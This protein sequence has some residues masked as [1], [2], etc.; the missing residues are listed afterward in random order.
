MQLLGELHHASG[1]LSKILRAVS[2]RIPHRPGFWDSLL[3]KLSFSEKKT[4][5]FG[6]PSLSGLVWCVYGDMVFSF[7]SL[8]LEGGRI[9]RGLRFLLIQGTINDCSSSDNYYS[10]RLPWFRKHEDST[11]VSDSCG[12]SMRDSSPRRLLSFQALWGP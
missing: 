2:C 3:R 1:F 12:R 5:G 8:Q 11:P 7:F 9:R 10:V 4:L 6:F